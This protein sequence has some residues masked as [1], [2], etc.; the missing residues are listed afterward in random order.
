MTR[1]RKWMLAMAAACGLLALAF[2]WL[3]LT[4]ERALRVQSTL[5]W[6]PLPSG[7]PAE[8]A[9]LAR[10]M[11]CT[12]CHGPALEGR[13]F[14][15]IPYVARLVAPNLTVARSRYPDAAFQQLM[16]SGAK[17]DGKL[18]LVMPNKAFQRL[19]DDQLADLF[20]FLQ[21]TPAVDDGLPPRWIGPLA[22]IGML[23][24][25][26]DIDAMR[27]DPPE[28]PPVL[29]DRA[30]PDHGRH[31][32]QVACGECHGLD[33]AGDPQ[34]GTPPLS[35]LLAYDLP[36]FARLMREGVTLAGGES[37][38]GF[39]SA[40]ARHRFGVLRDD[41][42]AAMKAVFPAPGDDH[43]GRPPH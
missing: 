27:A 42:I 15:E 34:A 37:A 19:R 36:A 38:S 31:L 23:S 5:A 35:V 18:A 20:A 9:R 26:Y 28:S 22:R 43:A 41:E 17:S 4:T 32:L 13:V 21:A 40:V 14:V 39:M 2:L 29:A 10:V 33:F 25:E 3:H 8:G 7:D 1:T 16:R 11:G 12:A 30:Q 6:S 24:G